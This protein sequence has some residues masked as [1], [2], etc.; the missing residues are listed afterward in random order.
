MKRLLINRMPGVY[1]SLAAAVVS[2]AGA[3]LYIAL[4]G[5]DRTFTMLGFVL[6]LLGAVSTGLVVLTRLKLA[7][8]VPAV[9]YAASFG[10][11]LRVAVPSLSDVWNKVNFIGGNAVAGCTFAGVF[12]LCA[13]LGCVSCFLGTGEDLPRHT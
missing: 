9:L 12:L 4:D 11:V 3:A 2:L 6:A 7:P 13:V 5:S 1:V 10:T 8:I